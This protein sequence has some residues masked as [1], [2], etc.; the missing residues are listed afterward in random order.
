MT[1][2]RAIDARLSCSQRFKEAV[3]HW[4]CF[5]LQDRCDPWTSYCFSPHVPFLSFQSSRAPG[6]RFEALQA[7]VHPVVRWRWAD[8]KDSVSASRSALCVALGIGVVVNHSAPLHRSP[9]HALLAYFHVVIVRHTQ[10]CASRPPRK[11][12]LP[13]LLLLQV[14][15]AYSSCRRRR[16]WHLFRPRGGLRMASASSH[17]WWS[18]I[19][20]QGAHTSPFRVFDGHRCH[21]LQSSSSM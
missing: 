18:F 13:L 4:I 3:N 7:S 2:K 16:R 17:A 1:Y 9:V 21:R 12:K 19:A 14:L 20:P 8:R 11:S 15:H 5:F 10:L 6:R